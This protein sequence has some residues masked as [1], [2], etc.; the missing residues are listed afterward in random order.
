[1]GGKRAAKELSVYHAF[2]VI[3]GPKEYRTYRPEV[4]H[5]NVEHA[6]KHDENDSAPLGLESDDHHDAGNESEQADYDTPEGPLA[7]EDE[8]DEQEDKKN[9]TSELEV[10]LAVLLVKLRETG[11]N[12]PLANP[13]IRKDHEKTTDHTQV[14][15]EEVQVKDQSV[16]KGLGHDNPQ[17]SSNG[18]FAVLPCDNEDRAS[19]HGNDVGDQEKMCDAPRDCKMPAKSASHVLSLIVA[20]Y[21]L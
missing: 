1:V 9:A 3:C 11:R 17:E 6:E 8:S 7:R 4:V 18:I 2:L 10:H 5:E 13:G 15:Q 20:Q 19:G 16:T 21:G 14:A 12:K